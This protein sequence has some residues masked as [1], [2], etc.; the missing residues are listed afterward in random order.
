MIELIVV[1]ITKLKSKSVRKHKY[2]EHEVHRGHKCFLAV[3]VTR[4][5]RAAA[6][7]PKIPL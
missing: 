5:L 1:V 2:G 3:A 4:N 6:D 7:W